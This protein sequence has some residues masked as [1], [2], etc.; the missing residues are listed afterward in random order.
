MRFS[1][2]A[3]AILT[4]IFLCFSLVVSSMSF[5]A[6]TTTPAASDG[7]KLKVEK[8]TASNE[9]YPDTAPVSKLL[10]GDITDNSYWTSDKNNV[11]VD[12]DLGKPY[13]MTVVKMAFYNS[14][15]QQCKFDLAVSDDG[16]TWTDVSKNNA[17][18][19]G[20]ATLQP[21]PVNKTGRYLRIIGH[22]NTT[23]KWYMFTSINEVEIY[24]K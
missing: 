10:D 24:G 2:K 18:K 12:F 21:F 3:T 15:T 5:A 14:S 22:G 19:Q 8:V 13:N 20:D 4:V 23:V 7:D 16:K 6:D 11:T 17:S 1:K 9:A